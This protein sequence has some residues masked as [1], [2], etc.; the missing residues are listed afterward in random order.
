MKTTH[1][2][3]PAISGH[4]LYLFLSVIGFTSIFLI[5]KK[6]RNLN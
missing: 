5:R 3:G 2:P 6:Y 1:P 4:Q